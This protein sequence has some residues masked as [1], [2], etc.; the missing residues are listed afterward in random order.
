MPFAKNIAKPVTDLLDV[1]TQQSFLNWLEK[2]YEKAR[3]DF[4][5]KDADYQNK[6]QL[7]GKNT[8]T[9]KRSKLSRETDTAFTALLDAI[10]QMD[11][12]YNDIV[13]A[14]RLFDTIKEAHQQ[15]MALMTAHDY[16]E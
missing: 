9:K 6:L 7:V 8:E 11:K 15:I 12:H 1:K 2:Q 3:S 14:K 16:T 4:K 13:K 5:A 10:E